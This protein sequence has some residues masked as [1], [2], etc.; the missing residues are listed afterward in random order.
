MSAY[1]SVMS[2]GSKVLEE[3]HVV[4]IS[5]TVFSKNNITQL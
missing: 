1:V 3:Q 5:Q 2:P 4:S